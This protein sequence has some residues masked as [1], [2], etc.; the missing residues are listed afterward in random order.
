MRPNKSISLEHRIYL[1]EKKL[2]EDLKESDPAYDIRSSDPEKIFAALKKGADIDTMDAQGKTPLLRLCENYTYSDPLS[3]KYISLLLKKGARVNLSDFKG[4]T[5]LYI[6]ITKQSKDLCKLLLDN[7]A[8]LFYEGYPKEN[9]V[10]EC[11]LDLIIR[12]RPFNSQV[13]REYLFTNKF[14]P[15]IIKKGR[16]GSLFVDLLRW[17][18][19]RSNPDLIEDFIDSCFKASSNPRTFLLQFSQRSTDIIRFAREGMAEAAM[20]AL[21]KNG[22][23]YNII[24]TSD[25]NEYKP[26]QLQTVLDL[27]Q[28]YLDNSLKTETVNLDITFELLLRTFVAQDVL[29]IQVPIDLVCNVFLSDEQAVRG[30][31]CFLIM[32]LQNSILSGGIKKSEI[33]TYIQ[34]IN[35]FINKSHY[36]FSNDS[37]YEA[38]ITNYIRKEGSLKDKSYNPL[39][40]LIARM[41]M[42]NVDGLN[43]QHVIELLFKSKNDYFIEILTE[44][45]ILESLDDTNIGLLQNYFY[46]NNRSSYISNNWMPYLDEF[47]SNSYKYKQNKFHEDTAFIAEIINSI[48]SDE[49]PRELR[50]RVDANPSILASREIQRE[51][52]NPR[53][54]TQYTARNYRNT[55]N[56]WL[57]QNKEETSKYDF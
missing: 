32:N 50:N 38:M 37:L 20:N 34:A 1:L 27:S 2:N 14:M 31:L 35:S 47:F 24:N 28:R 55:Y 42:L 57:S 16:C 3:I 10:A 9:G 36:N 12:Y 13:L 43:S 33:K 26:T 45:N 44:F 19:F 49:A 11:L 53:Y 22:W 52:R 18:P 5:P 15:E 54:D 29:K 21:A 17:S 8:D 23:F 7:G 56:R 41:T 40:R 51:L 30:K 39:T 48:R 46:R 6:G 25:F 4:V